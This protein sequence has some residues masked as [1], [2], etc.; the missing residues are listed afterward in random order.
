MERRGKR[1]GEGKGGREGK[2][3]R[4]EGDVEE[5]RSGK[6]EGRRRK[7]R[8]RERLKEREE[9][10]KLKE[11]CWPFKLHNNTSCLPTRQPA[12]TMQ[13]HRCQHTCHAHQA[14]EID[15]TRSTKEKAF[16]L[17][18]GTTS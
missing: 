12:T 10:R 17:S 14:H 5:S 18:K 13:L 8:E 7:Q 2:K 11:V 4:E 6:R 16:S 9:G 15:K 1:G 3:E